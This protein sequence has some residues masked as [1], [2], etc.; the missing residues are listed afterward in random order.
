MLC[1]K[2][3]DSEAMAQKNWK[4]RCEASEQRVRELEREKEGYNDDLLIMSARKADLARLTDLSEE[5]KKLKQKVSF[6]K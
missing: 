1:R 3:A 6:Y 2:L 4:V 5:N